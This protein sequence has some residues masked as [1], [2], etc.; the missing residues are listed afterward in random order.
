MYGAA[1]VIAPRV[2]EALRTM[3]EI[4]V[5]PTPG[6]I[7]GGGIRRAEETIKSVP[8]V[9]SMVRGAETR[10]L[11]DFNRGAVNFALRPAG[12]NVGTKTPVGRQLIAEA[13]DLL[14]SGYN[15]ALDQITNARVDQIFQQRVQ[16][17]AQRAAQRLG[18]KG[19]RAFNN[20]IED[21]RSLPAMKKSSFTGKEIKRAISG[22]REDADRLS[23]NVDEDVTQA[24]ELIREL[25]D[26]VS[27]LMKRNTTPDNAARLTG[28]D[29]AYAGFQRVREAS[30]RGR[31]GF[32]TPFQ[33]SQSIKRG[34]AMRG[35]REF[36]RGQGL[37]QEIA[38][39]AE[40][41]IS[42]R[43]PDSGTPERLMFPAMVGGAAYVD[44]LA[45]A[46]VAGAAAPYT[47]VGQNLI[48]QLAT[49][50]PSAGQQMLAEGLRRSIL[51][52]AVAGG[53]VASK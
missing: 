18:R 38:E 21:V 51:P 53:A 34:E 15:E 14:S 36:A 43:V 24:G 1:N 48:A 46:G 42:S 44:P 45:A 31:E 10:A 3:R 50:T 17:I 35:S 39:A 6:Q 25:R 29:R 27:D 9:G 5:R 30:E 11:E 16:A 40:E 47:R 20:A 12:L 8:L 41:V 2:T 22:L 4:G 28:L 52:A 37:G 26:E 33:L 23:K 49:R 32:F 13:D 7:A 19:Q